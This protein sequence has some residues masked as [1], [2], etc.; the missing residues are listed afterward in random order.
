MICMN[1]Q[2]TL[3]FIRTNKNIAQRELLQYVDASVYSKIE[4][5]KKNLRVSELLEILD[6]LSIPFDEFS[7]YADIDYSQKKFRALLGR[8]K[9]TPQDPT[10]K[11]E[12]LIYFYSLEFSINMPLNELSNYVLVKTYFSSHWEEISKL[13]ELELTCIYNLLSTKNYFFHYDYAI[14]ANTIYLFDNEQIDFLV[15]KS[16]PVPDMSYRNAATKEF[17]TNLINNLITT[18]LRK[19]EYQKCMFYLSLAKQEKQNYDL[20][21]KIIVHFLESLTS[22]LKTN[23]TKYAE[24]LTY[25]INYLTIIEEQDLAQ[26]L[27]IE[28]ESLLSKNQE[29]LILLRNQFNQ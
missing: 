13:T 23:D 3:Y 16:F 6:R 28:L 9:N 11:D 25:H 1:I 5:G 4:S 12:L 7:K 21:Y 22:F 27:K 17:V 26:S 18:L 8:Y 20:T 29:Q 19:K 24:H 14:L 10:I 15:K 2:E